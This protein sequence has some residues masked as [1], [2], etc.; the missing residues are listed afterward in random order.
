VKQFITI[1]HT[2][3]EHHVNGMVGS[4]TDWHLTEKGRQQAARIADN[5]AFFLLGD[6]VE[7]GPTEQLFSAPHDRRTEDYLSGRFG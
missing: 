1:Q 5:T 3:S 2:Q 4:W 7:Y 6:M